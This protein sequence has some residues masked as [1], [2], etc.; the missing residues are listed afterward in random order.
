MSTTAG[1]RLYR[2]DFAGRHNIATGMLNTALTAVSA[3]VVAHVV[4]VTGAASALQTA[5]TIAAIT[6]LGVM[7]TLIWG[8]FAKKAPTGS[9]IA[10]RIICWFGAG[11]WSTLFA[12]QPW[13]LTTIFSYVTTLA[14]STTIIG[15]LGWLTTP[16]IEP[17]QKEQYDQEREREHQQRIRDDLAMQWRDRISRLTRI[18]FSDID[19]PAI[20]NYPHKTP[21]GRNVGYTLEVHLPP[22]GHS[23]QTLARERRSFEN[24]LDLPPGC[25]VNV[26]M[27]H[28][29]R[30]AMVDVTIVNVLSEE[31][32][33]PTD[34]SPLSV[35][36][37]LPMM[38]SR[39]GDVRGPHIRSYNSGIFGEGGSGKSNAGQVLGAGVAR[40]VDAH[41]CDIDVTGVR[42]SMPLIR[43]YLEGRAKNPAVW[44]VASDLQEAILM[45]RAL[46]RAAIAR[47]NGYN[48]LKLSV[49]DDKMPISPEFPA[50][51]V[52]CDEIKH[53]TSVA[54]DP[55][56][57]QLLRRITDDHRDPG[58]RAI[59]LGLRGTNDIIEQGIQVQLQN[60]GVLRAQSKAEYTAVFGGQATGLDPSDAPYPGCIQ[61]R[62]GSGG[63]IQPYH[64][65]RL[66][67]KQIDEIAVAVSDYQ[68]GVDALTWLALN[69]RDA[70]GKPFVDLLDGEL[71][72]CA[73]R[74][75][76][77]RAKL[78]YS[79]TGQS[80]KSDKATRRGLGNAP[81]IDQVQEEIAEA[82]R[83][84]QEAIKRRQEQDEKDKE[85]RDD[86]EEKIK[87]FDVDATLARIFDHQ[88]TTG[89]NPTEGYT[90][91]IPP[92]SD[93]TDPATSG[94][95]ARPPVVDNFAITAEI[96]KSAGST[97]IEMSAI[98]STLATRGIV[99][100]RATVHKWLKTMV[101]P[102]GSY[103]GIVEWRP[104]RPEGRNGRWYPIDQERG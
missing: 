58:F 92:S 12:F 17:S 67:G 29:R 82:V 99:V 10:H 3:A 55:I 61:M 101:G 96:I 32:P 41:L 39:R 70:D 40:M 95:P 97:G 45:L 63:P 14:I 69:G 49:G 35:H 77:L 84:V 36:H 87:A 21:D 22:G 60:V 74:W 23:W 91:D 64:V 76:R 83:R 100:D 50:F 78:G 9:V 53:L 27:G 1:R 56:A 47:N 75:D 103:Q 28:T 25:D 72:C 5:L 54:A 66:V 86:I 98:H 94:I 81:T 102:G 26:R 80:D 73:T 42:L 7:M 62:L 90:T 51:I 20:E 71:D 31:Q 88:I 15:F 59:L 2:L 8:S 104:D 38:V 37:E 24:D 79:T 68:P 16:A 48:D 46:N 6:I 52:R 57:R 85:R 43:A 65:W 34:Y 19:I 33:Y 18:P 44:W 4:T 30:V 93:P 11:L 89:T 13:N